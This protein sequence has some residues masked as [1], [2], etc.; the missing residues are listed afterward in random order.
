MSCT[1]SNKHLVHLKII[2]HPTVNPAFVSF[3]K[4]VSKI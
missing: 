1:I 4:A 2:F 3:L